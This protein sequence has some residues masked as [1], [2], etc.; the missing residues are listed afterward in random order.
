M[1]E[2]SGAHRRVIALALFA[3]AGLMAVVAAL[4]AGGILPIPDQYRALTSGAMFLAAAVDVLIGLRFLV[5]S[6]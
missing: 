2:P 3:S 4:S 5:S 6:S 1:P